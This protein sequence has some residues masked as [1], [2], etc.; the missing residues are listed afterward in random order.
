MAGPSLKNNDSI[1]VGALGVVSDAPAVCRLGEFLLVHHHEPT[2]E[3]NSFRC[4]P[5]E[6][7]KK[8]LAITNLTNLESNVAA[9]LHH[10]CQLH[11]RVRT[12]SCHS[13]SLRWRSI[14][15]LVMS[16]PANQLL[17]QL[18]SAY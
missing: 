13:A 10:S 8:Y 17:S 9:G 15:T 11:Q 2:V 18:S 4:V 7:L 12:I 16:M 1:G 5:N 6:A 3:R 14:A